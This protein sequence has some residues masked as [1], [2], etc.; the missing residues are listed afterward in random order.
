MVPSVW[1]SKKTFWYKRRKQISD[2]HVKRSIN[3]PFILNL[4]VLVLDLG[5]AQVCSS[6]N[7]HPNT[8]QNHTTPHPLQRQPTPQSSKPATTAPKTPHP[9][10][11]NPTAAFP[12]ALA[13]LALAVP[14]A[15]TPV[16]VPFVV[17]VGAL[18][19]ALPVAL[20]LLRS[21]L[22]TT[23]AVVSAEGRCVNSA[24]PV[25]SV[26]GL[27][28]VARAELAVM[29]MGRSVAVMVTGTKVMAALCIVVEK[30][31]AFA[32]G[33]QTDCVQVARVVPWRTQST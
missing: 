23:P 22:V 31:P 33:P 12:L 3:S 20:A 8:T 32:D 21:R 18:P 28:V 29:G 10:L 13:W 4:L 6:P 15:D 24:V 7:P 26:A 14:L 5:S 17:P 27:V 1:V 30:A 16:N 11:S 25:G 2:S 19:L 9:A